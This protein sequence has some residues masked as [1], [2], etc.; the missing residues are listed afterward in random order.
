MR[1]L[2]DHKITFIHNPKT[3][4]TSISQWLDENFKT[5]EGRKHGGWK[6]VD[7]FFPNTIFT[8]GV[9]RNPWARMASWYKFVGSGSFESWIV[10]RFV[11]GDAGTSMGLTFKPQ[12]AWA[13][14]W[15]NL[16]TPQADWL[17]DK[18][19]YTLRFE[20]L[21]EDFVEIQK[22]LDCK[23][24]LPMLNCTEQYDYRELY[25]EDT[26]EIVKDY[27]MKDIIRYNYAF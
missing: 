2:P 21:Q 27:F 10:D 26:K 9:V 4:G 1:Y 11:Y 6:E 22:I 3:A 17:G 25:N 19:N 8:F 5:I 7:E 18:I 23:K 24:P 20:T 13:R 14:Q 15:Y 12:L 16:G